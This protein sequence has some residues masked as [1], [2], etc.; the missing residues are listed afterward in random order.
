MSI[1]GFRWGLPLGG[2]RK[3]FPK[4]GSG[5]LSPYT[6]NSPFSP[7]DF[8]HPSK[9]TRDSWFRRSIVNEWQR[10]D[11][12]LDTLPQDDSKLFVILFFK[13]EQ[14]NRYWWLEFAQATDF[15]CKH[16]NYSTLLFFLILGTLNNN[17]KTRV[18]F[19]CHM[20]MT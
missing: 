2:R 16:F 8:R 11:F 9:S 3:F 18:F 1:K 5:S 20:S 7:E 15:P 19:Y 12:L 13:C 6:S 17:K 4:I 14:T 10:E